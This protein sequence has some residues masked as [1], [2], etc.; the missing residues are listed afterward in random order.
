M[1]ERVTNDIPEVFEEIK[2]GQACIEATFKVASA[3]LSVGSAEQQ[4]EGLLG[5]V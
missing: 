3:E 1:E 2:C 4:P 5:G